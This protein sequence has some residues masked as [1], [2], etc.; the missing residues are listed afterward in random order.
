M[1]RRM[2]SLCLLLVDA[3]I[4]AFV[5]FIALYLRF[6]GTVDNRYFEL[7][8]KY[9]PE[10]VL[11]RLA[12]FYLFGLYQRLWRYASIHELLGIIFAVTI[13]S[14]VISVYMNIISANIPRSISIISW[15]LVIILV[16]ASRLFIRILH[17]IRQ[18]QQEES[19]H[20]L[21]V[22]AGDAGAMIAREINQRYCDTKKLIGFIDDDKYKHN[23][24]L[25]GVK[26]LGDSQDI[27]PIAAKYKVNEII[28]AIPSLSGSQLREI[29]R[30]CK[31]TGC[32][33]KIVPGIYELMEGKVTV[34]QLRDVDL[35]DL[36]RREPVTLDLEQIASCLTG[37]RVLITGAGGSIGSEL[38]RQIAKLSP[39]ELA[40]LGKGENSIYEIDRELREKYSGLT[41]KPI[42]ADVR[43]KN[44]INDI[45]T[46]LKPEVIFHAAAH[47]HVPLMESQPVEAVRNNIFGTKTVAEAADKA[48]TGIFIMISTDKAVNPTSVMGAT[49]RVA[50]LV[51]QN[52]NSVSNTRFAAVRFGNVLGSRGSVVPLFKKQIAKGGPITITHPDMKRYFMTIPEATQLVLQAG[53]LASGGEVFVLDMG[54]PVKIVDMASDLIELSGLERGQDIEIKFTGLRPGEKLFEELLTAEEG[55]TSTKHEKIFVANLKSVDVQ[56]FQM[57]LEDLRRASSSEEIISILGKLVPSYYKAREKYCDVCI[58]T[59]KSD[60]KVDP[61]GVP[62]QQQAEHTFAS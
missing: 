51:I 7:I 28:I 50:E 52:I 30:G 19:S 44:R 33:V 9:L 43:D 14:L 45:F 62:V 47:K 16:G 57:G 3:A 25:F 17:F 2:V 35:E 54:E 26:I 32:T 39:S 22:G 37:K 38:C 1:R 42:I 5:P 59:A 4:V 20:I 55:T 31:K 61:T 23:Q 13:S 41:I 56:Q 21:I 53:T 40:L 36:L 8:F 29:I 10:I 6:E 24:M 48:G 58:N 49:K 12:I 34:N 46:R 27:T 11:I 18:K 60:V 15:L